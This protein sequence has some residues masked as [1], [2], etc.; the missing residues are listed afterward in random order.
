MGYISQGRPSYA[1]VAITKYYGIYYFQLILHATVGQLGALS[2]SSSPGPKYCKMPWPGAQDMDKQ[3]LAL[4][5][6][7]Q[8]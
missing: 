8:K 3:T 5:A 6:S 4:N 1:A 2:S 7:A